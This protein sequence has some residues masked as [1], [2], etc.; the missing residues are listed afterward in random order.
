MDIQHFPTDM[1]LLKNNVT[2]IC[3]LTE[4]FEVKSYKNLSL[5]LS[6]LSLSKMGLEQ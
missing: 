1:P 6:L 3:C 4:G 2:F 5:S